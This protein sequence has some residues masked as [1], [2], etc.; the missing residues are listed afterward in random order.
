MRWRDDSVG[1]YPD[2]VDQVPVEAFLEP[3]PARMRQIAERLRRVVSDAVP[4]AIER[5][6]PGWRLIGY[7]LPLRA[8]PRYFAFV[9]PEDAHVHLGFEYGALMDDPNK[10]LGGRELRR[11]RFVTLVTGD[12]YSDAVLV[13]MAQ[14]GARVARMTRAEQL[15]RL[16]DRGGP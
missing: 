15:T 10:A 5:V 6:R 4:E 1:D 13:A 3:Y 14:E 8:R 12:E 9:A 7:D 16:L 11:V 2:I